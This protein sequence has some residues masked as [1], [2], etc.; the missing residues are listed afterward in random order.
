MLKRL[1]KFLGRDPKGRFF[2]NVSDKIKTQELLKDKKIRCC[3]PHKLPHVIRG[4]VCD[5]PCHIHTT[6]WR[7]IHHI[8]FCK[9]LKCPHYK[10]MMKARKK[11]KKK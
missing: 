7:D 2:I 4:K 10:D 11:H 9:I 3:P 5:E 8:P 6:K 1:K